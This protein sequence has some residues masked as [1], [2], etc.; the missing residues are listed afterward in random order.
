MHGVFE[1]LHTVL[2]DEIDHLGHAN[3]LAYLQWMLDAAAAH[4][5]AQGWNVE[6]YLKLGAAWVVRSHEI[7][8]LLPALEGDRL[9]VRTWLTDLKHFSTLRR[10]RMMRADDGRVLA[11]AATQWAFVDL[12]SGT[13]KRIP[14][15][16]LAAFEFAPDEEPSAA[17]PPGS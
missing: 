8:Y 16:V 3:N 12:A 14:P 9:V 13:L 5:A 6:R 11:S 10:Y 4:S 17:D 7:K 1:H 2:A 15:E